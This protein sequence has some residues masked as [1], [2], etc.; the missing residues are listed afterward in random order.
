MDVSLI[1][2]LYMNFSWMPQGDDIDIVAF[3]KLQ[4]EMIYSHN[5]KKNNSYLPIKFFMDI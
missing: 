5:E 2:E 4:K 3:N 1:L